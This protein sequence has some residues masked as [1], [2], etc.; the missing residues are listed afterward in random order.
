MKIIGLTGAIGSGKSTV[1]EM[2]AELGVPVIDADKISHE[3][4]R[5]DS[6]VTQKIIDH[7]GPEYSDADHHLDRKKLRE[8]IFN[9]PEDKIWLE[10]ILHPEIYKAIQS[11]INILKSRQSDIPNYIIVVI[12]LLFET[13]RPDYI[14]EVWNIDAPEDLQIQRIMTRDD[15]SETLAKKIISQQTSREE[16]LKKA[17]RV[18]GNNQNKNEL[19]KMLLNLHLEYSKKN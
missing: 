13:G 11:K 8:K 16:R 15:I 9:S 18:I 12:P 1:A 10:N 19:K 14:D 3:L 6:V 7:F 5:S 2:F 4:T 17:D